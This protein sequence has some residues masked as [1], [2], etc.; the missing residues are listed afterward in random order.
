MLSKDSL[1]ELQAEN[2]A[3]EARFEAERGEWPTYWTNT[4]IVCSNGL[5]GLCA[6]DDDFADFCDA[7][8]IHTLEEAMSVMANITAIHSDPPARKAYLAQNGLKGCNHGM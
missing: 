1:E 6:E 5:V 2:E 3:A 4:R 7:N 8:D